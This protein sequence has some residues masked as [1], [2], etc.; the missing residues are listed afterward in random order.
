MIT[1]ESTVSII[2]PMFNHYN[3][4]HQCLFDLYKSRNK[5]KEIIVVN[6]GSTDDEVTTGLSWWKKNIEYPVK[7]LNLEENQ[8]FT[9]AV[10]RGVAVSSGDVVIILSND[11][12]VY[13][14]IATLVLEKLIENEQRIVGAELLSHDTGWN[15]F[16]GVIYPYIYGYLMACTREAWDEVGGMDEIYAPSDFEDVDFSTTALSLGMD[17]SVIA[18]QSV[19]HSGGGSYGYTEERRAR[20]VRNQEKFK[21]KWSIE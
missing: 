11:V 18:P 9:G 3:L 19:H 16:N 6:D 2:I 8:G 12:R 17:L 14:D 1:K 13:A 5:V 7:V 20:T 4:T 21:K 15:T 10:N